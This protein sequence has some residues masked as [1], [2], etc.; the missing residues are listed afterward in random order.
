M[1]LLYVTDNY[2]YQTRDQHFWS[3]ASF[4]LDY[5]LSN[6]PSI[7][8]WTFWGRIK[9]VDDSSHLYLPPDRVNKC[10]VSYSGPRVNKKKRLLWPLLIIKSIFPLRAEIAEADIVFL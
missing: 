4:P 2:F 6:L 5:I 1:K 7:S 10:S 9:S 3:T 8:Q